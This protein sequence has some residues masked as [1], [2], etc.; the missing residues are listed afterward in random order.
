MT[1]IVYFE[2][3]CNVNRSRTPVA[4]EGVYILCRSPQAGRT[5][6][7]R[8]SIWHRSADQRAE[9]FGNGRHDLL[10]T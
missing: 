5:S 9:G 4:G 1:D 10:G 8:A 2:I 6:A 7:L 3:Y